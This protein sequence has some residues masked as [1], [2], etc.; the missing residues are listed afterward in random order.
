VTKKRTRSEPPCV[1]RF[2]LGWPSIEDCRRAG[3]RGREGPDRD[4]GEG[5]A[6]QQERGK[7]VGERKAWLEGFGRVLEIF[8][9]I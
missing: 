1:K 4:R 5:W 3:P 8:L 6:G 7:K 9:F 2:G